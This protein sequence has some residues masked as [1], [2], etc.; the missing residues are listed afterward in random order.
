MMPG[1][2]GCT[3]WLSLQRCL[4]EAIQAFGQL[5]PMQY[6]TGWVLACIGRAYFEAV[7][8][9]SAAEAFEWARKADPARLEVL[10]PGP[11]LAL[12]IKAGARLDVAVMCKCAAENAGCGAAPPHLLPLLRRAQ[13]LARALMAGTSLC[14]R[15]EHHIITAGFAGRLSH[16]H[17]AQ[18]EIGDARHREAGPGVLLH[19]GCRVCTDM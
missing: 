9:K 2:E 11:S 7:D 6:S 5:P 4:Q 3:C 15:A 14:K 8:Y 12:P 19:A 16:G 18:K 1:M 13:L 10:L 17:D